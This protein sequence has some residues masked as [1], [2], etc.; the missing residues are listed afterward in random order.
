MAA[1]NRKWLMGDGQEDLM[2]CTTTCNR[3][4]LMEAHQ[5]NSTTT[6]WVNAAATLIINSGHAAWQSGKAGD[7]KNEPEMA[8]L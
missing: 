6:L 3:K 4:D 1:D 5:R 8:P 7:V 2:F